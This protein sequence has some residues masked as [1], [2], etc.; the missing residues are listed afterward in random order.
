MRLSKLGAALAVLMGLTSMAGAA[1]YRVQRSVEVQA[2]GIELWHAIGD[3]CDVDDWHPAISGCSLKVSDGRLQRVLV[4]VDGAQFVERRIAAEAG[5]SYTYRIV[6]S[7]LAVEKYTATLSIQP[8]ETTT[9]SWSARFSAD[10]PGM[11]AAVAGVI[12]TGLAAIEAMFAD[13]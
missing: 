3:F 10:D 6:D 9:V 13:G 8:G 12:E 2:A 11:A 1:D 4:T 5:L 7:P